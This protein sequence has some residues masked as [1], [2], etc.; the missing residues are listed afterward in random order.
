MTM[1]TWLFWALLSATFA[2][3]V[4]IFAKGGLQKVDS[5]VAQFVRTAIVFAAIAMIVIPT[6]KLSGISHWR[7]QT[8]VLIVLSGLATAASWICYFRALDVGSA[9]R[10]AAVDKLSVAIVAVAAVFFLGERLGTTGWVGIV[11]VTIGLVLI[12]LKS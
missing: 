8:W 4:A 5:D 9:A 7:A 3:L 11:L 2:A 10:V 12:S 1:P 6:G